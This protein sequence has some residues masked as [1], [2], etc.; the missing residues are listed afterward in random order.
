MIV[1]SNLGGSEPAFWYVMAALCFAGAPINYV[2]W[3]RSFGNGTSP[4]QRSRY[5][6]AWQLMP[7]L[8]MVFLAR[9]LIP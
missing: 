7:L 2:L 8:G 9:V 1:A 5:Q 3:K 4:R 6:R